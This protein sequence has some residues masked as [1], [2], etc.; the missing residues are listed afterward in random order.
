MQENDFDQ[1]ID[2]CKEEYESN[3]EEIVDLRNKIFYLTIEDI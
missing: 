2:H 3:I 1:Y